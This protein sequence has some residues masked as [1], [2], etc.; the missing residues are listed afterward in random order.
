[1]F[2]SVPKPIRFRSAPVCES[3]F[4]SAAWYKSDNQIFSL[5]IVLY[6]RILP[7]LFTAVHVTIPFV[8]GLIYAA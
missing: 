2:S 5:K 6:T 3:G 4:E 7:F 8:F 1:M